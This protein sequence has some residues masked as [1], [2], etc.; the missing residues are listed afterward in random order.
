MF[1]KRLPKAVILCQARR[2]QTCQD[3]HAEQE[4]EQHGAVPRGCSHSASQIGPITATLILFLPLF[5]H[6]THMAGGGQQG[7]WHWSFTG[8]STPKELEAS[9]LWAVLHTPGLEEESISG[10]ALP[11]L[12]LPQFHQSTIPYPFQWQLPP[13]RLKLLFGSQQNCT[14]TQDPRLREE[15][16]LLKNTSGHRENQA[17]GSSVGQSTALGCSHSLF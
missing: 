2:S 3:T 12:H 4:W 7:G 6:I 16:Q 15:H 1:Q 14:T 13:R 17:G 10:L 11:S 5:P 9:P 8:I